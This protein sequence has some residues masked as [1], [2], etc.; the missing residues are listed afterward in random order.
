M[1][2]IKSREEGE[3]SKEGIDDEKP[4]KTKRNL[5]SNGEKIILEIAG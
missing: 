2:L 5:Q 4:H 1:K 3:S